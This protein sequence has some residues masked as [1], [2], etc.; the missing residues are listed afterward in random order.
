M[1]RGV[2][3]V[4]KERRRW[5]GFTLI[6]L[7]AVIAVIGTLAGLLLPALSAA[8][9]RALRI[10]CMNNLKQIIYTGTMS[11]DNHQQY[12]RPT[13]RSKFS[14]RSDVGRGLV[15]RTGAGLYQIRF[16]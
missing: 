8:K 4:W 9:A 3:A 1:G 10:Q 16:I 14:F 15:R 7:L 13:R 6:E 11:I 2:S 12:F 5:C